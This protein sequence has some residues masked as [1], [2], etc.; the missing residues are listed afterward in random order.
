[1]GFI[2]PQKCHSVLNAD[3]GV[4]WSGRSTEV[5]LPDVVRAERHRKLLSHIVCMEEKVQVMNISEK[6]EVTPRV[7]SL[8]QRQS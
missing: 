5:S 8:P 4:R 1:M 6:P 7:T 2:P 3:S